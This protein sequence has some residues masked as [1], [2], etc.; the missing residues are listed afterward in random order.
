MGIISSIIGRIGL[1]VA[2][3]AVA[4]FLLF[5]F[6]D[7]IIGAVT[8]G[9]ATL[10]QIVTAPF[11]SFLQ[12]IQTGF[13]NIP[14]QIDIEFPSFNFGF[15]PPQPIGDPIGDIG[16][17][18]DDFVKFFE[19]LFGGN[20]NGAAPPPLPPPPTQDQSSLTPFAE[21]FITT[22]Q[23]S[24]NDPVVF[25]SKTLAEIQELN[26]GAIGLFDILATEQ[27]EFFAL[28]QQEISFIGAENLKFSGQLFE[29]VGSL[30]EAINFA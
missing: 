22:T 19:N 11:G 3:L 2:A 15:A 7:R 28:S 16:K 27:T 4:G 1:P 18:F 5:T 17:G 24:L 10:G 12:G 13:G 21:T 26:V 8:G 20:G 9:A 23:A 25:S 14:S 29:E 6:R 30:Q